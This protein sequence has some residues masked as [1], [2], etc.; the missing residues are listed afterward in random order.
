MYFHKLKEIGP[1]MP[2][3]SLRHILRTLLVTFQVPATQNIRYDIDTRRIMKRVL[4]KNSNCADIGAHEGEIL[5]RMMKF[6]PEGKMT[7]FE[8]LPHM[9]EYLCRKYE[10]KNV[11]IFPVALYDRKG[12]TAFNYVVD[13]PAYSGIRKRRYDRE[14]V[15][16]KELTVET[17]LMDNLI[18]SGEPVRLMKIDVDG[19]EFAVLKGGAATIRRCRPYIIFECGLGAADFYGTTPGDVFDFVKESCGLC[20]STMRGF[21]TSKPVLSRQAFCDLFSSGKE[22][23][24]LAHPGP[25]A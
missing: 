15:T 23:Y 6:A 4:E 22:Y 2:S 11:R 14:N 7:A 5:D 1:C 13:D 12:T 3:L 21:L 19:A 8:P 20:L 25:S 24:F 10:G 16:I 17:D 18:P 9:Y